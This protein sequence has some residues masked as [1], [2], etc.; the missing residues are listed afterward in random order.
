MVSGSTGKLGII[1]Q[2]REVNTAITVRYSKVRD[3]I[4]NF[5]CNQAR[6]RRN[7]D[8]ARNRFEAMANDPALSTWTREDARLSIDILDSLARMENITGGGHFEAPPQ[9]QSPLMLS[10]V[11]VSVNLDVLMIRDRRGKQ[12]VGGIL[13]RMTKADEETDAAKAKRE[14]IGSFA[15]TLA[16]MQIQTGTVGDRLP[17]HQICGSFDIQ[18]EDVHWAPRNYAA[19]AKDLENECRFIAAMWKAA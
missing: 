5:L 2:A 7:L 1:R 11:S 17:H 9:K 10:G 19:K 4:K 18:C 13:F 6:T 16:Y 14:Q 15:A 8:A 3:E 12:E